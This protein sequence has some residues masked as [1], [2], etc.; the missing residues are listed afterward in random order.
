MSRVDV[1]AIFTGFFPDQVG[2]AR[3]SFSG[4]S[5]VPGVASA[6]GVARSQD[7]MEM[8]A[9]ASGKQVNG[10]MIA[11]RVPQAS[12]APPNHDRFALPFL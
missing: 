8:A 5:E 11:K 6:T 2:Q 4:L 1:R 3:V 12:A 9:R 10:V 7:G